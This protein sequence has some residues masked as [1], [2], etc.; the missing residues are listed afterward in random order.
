M[1]FSEKTLMQKKNVIRD[2]GSYPTALKA[3]DKSFTFEGSLIGST[4]LIDLN[5]IERLVFYFR[6]VL[7]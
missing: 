4:E 2:V 5:R 6:F 7:E 1:N 3:C